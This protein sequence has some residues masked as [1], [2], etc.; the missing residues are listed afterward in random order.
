[1][2]HSTKLQAGSS[3]CLPKEGR[4]VAALLTIVSAAWP[5]YGNTAHC[6]HTEYRHW[7]VGHKKDT[8]NT[9]VLALLLPRS[10]L[11]GPPFAVRSGWLALPGFLGNDK[12]AFLGCL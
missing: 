8:S 7:L 2:T 3:A 12:M 4:D 1:M 9:S 10:R 6:V 5:P 11:L